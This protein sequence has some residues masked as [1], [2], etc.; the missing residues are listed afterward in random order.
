MLFFFRV[1][2]FKKPYTCSK[3]ST[4]MSSIHTHTHTQTHTH[5]LWTIPSVSGG[6]CFLVIEY[7]LFIVIIY[8]FYYTNC[9]IYRAQEFQWE[10]MYRICSGWGLPTIVGMEEKLIGKSVLLGNLGEESC[11][12]TVREREWWTPG[13]RLD[14][15]DFHS[16][17][18]AGAG[19]QLLLLWDN[20][21]HSQ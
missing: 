17:S 18:L 3:N 12:R 7:M 21:I 1:H 16:R 19:M 5:L 9:W 2:F 10:N 6:M 8:L 4:K 15:P 14:N 20:A 11:W 13:N